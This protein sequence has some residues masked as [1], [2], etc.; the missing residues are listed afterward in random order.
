MSIEMCRFSPQK[1]NFKSSPLLALMD[2]NE[3]FMLEFYCPFN[4]LHSKI[5]KLIFHVTNQMLLL[6]QVPLSSQLVNNELLVIFILFIQLDLFTSGL[7]S[8]LWSDDSNEDEEMD[9]PEELIS[10]IEV[11]LYGVQIR[12]FFFFHGHAELMGHI[13]AGTASEKTPIIQVFHSFRFSESMS[14]CNN[15]A[16]YYVPTFSSLILTH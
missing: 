8:F 10:G 12:P 3:H 14:I 16:S 1:L 13:W 11:A 5:G 2:S 6:T 15:V 7:S 4:A 9:E